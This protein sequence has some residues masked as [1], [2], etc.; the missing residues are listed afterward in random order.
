MYMPLY[1]ENIKIRYM[2]KKSEQFKAT[3]SIWACTVGIIAICVPM[4]YKLNNE[5]KLIPLAALCCATVGTV[6]VWRD[7]KKTEDNNLAPQK[8][9][10]VEQRIRDLEAIVS[11]EDYDLKARLKQFESGTNRTYQD[12][13]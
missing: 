6:A 3:T 10:L 7:D 5:P 12:H 8:V 11:S 13:R 4:R 9:E 1:I 2:S